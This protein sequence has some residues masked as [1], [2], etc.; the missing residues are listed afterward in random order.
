[1]SNADD[2]VALSQEQNQEG[3]SRSEHGGSARRQFDNIRG[4]VAGWGHVSSVSDTDQVVV[5]RALKRVA[6]NLLTFA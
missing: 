3:L 4:C 1:M 2:F 5:P 6:S